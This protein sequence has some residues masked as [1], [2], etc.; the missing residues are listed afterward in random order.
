METREII[1]ESIDYAVTEFIGQMNFED[2]DL[3]AFKQALADGIITID[4]IVHQFRI[5]LESHL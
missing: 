4:E 5:G 2:L 1:E 3:E